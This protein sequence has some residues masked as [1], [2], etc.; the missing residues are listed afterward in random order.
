MRVAV[1]LD[2]QYSMSNR[3]LEALYL[4]IGEGRKKNRERDFRC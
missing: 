2:M 4:V 3:H 1:T